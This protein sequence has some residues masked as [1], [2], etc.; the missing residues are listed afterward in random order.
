MFIPLAFFGEFGLLKG[1]KWCLLCI[2][3]IVRLSRN[4]VLDLVSFLVVCFSSPTLCL[5]GCCKKFTFL[6]K[7][8]CLRD[9]LVTELR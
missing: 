4:Q 7:I 1:C 8:P 9:F 2:V 3:L 6:V 5:I